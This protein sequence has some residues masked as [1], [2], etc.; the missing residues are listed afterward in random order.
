MQFTVWLE[1]VAFF[2]FL[3]DYANEK[4]LVSVL[5]FR[6]L[7]VIHVSELEKLYFVDHNQLC[8]TDPAFLVWVAWTRL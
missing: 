8:S 5:D 7:T 6:V 1:Q 3:I 2:E 4:M